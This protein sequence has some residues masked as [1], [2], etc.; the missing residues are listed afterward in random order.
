MQICVFLSKG[1]NVKRIINTAIRIKDYSWK[2]S[3][4]QNNKESDEHSAPIEKVKR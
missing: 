1:D 3:T 2:G 4:V